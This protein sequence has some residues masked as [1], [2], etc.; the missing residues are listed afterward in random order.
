MAL[1]WGAMGLY[2]NPLSHRQVEYADATVASE[3]VLRLISYFAFS[4]ASRSG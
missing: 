2:K 4:T 1:F 3:T